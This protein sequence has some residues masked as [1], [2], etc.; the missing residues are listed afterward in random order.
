MDV[1]SLKGIAVVSIEQGEKVGMIDNVLFDLENRRIIAFK[2]I[3]PVL[4]SSGGIVL[5]MYDVENIGKD[6]V[7][8]QHKDKIRE[9]KEE[10]DLQNRPD[11]GDL[12]SLRVVTEDGT[13][14]GNVA[15]VQFEPRNGVI[16]DLEITGTGMMSRLR[17][18]K[19]IP[20]RQIVSIG[21]DVVVVPDKYAPGGAESA[22]SDD[23][24]ALPEKSEDKDDDRIRN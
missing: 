6:A 10:R 24:V 12:S 3:K 1:K 4:M 11:L 2:M 19:S 18:N 9:L 17:R 16:T 7:M 15:T 14:V 23:P 13:F 20:A 22:K 21:A 5:R 8:I